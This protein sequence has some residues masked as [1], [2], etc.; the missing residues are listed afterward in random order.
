MNALAR[1]E[2]DAVAGHSRGEAEDMVMRLII[3]TMNTT[4][5]KLTRVADG[6]RSISPSVAA[7]V[8]HLAEHVAGVTLDALRTWPANPT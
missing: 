5:T 7:H 6:R 8:G 2:E 1:P 4:V 3:A